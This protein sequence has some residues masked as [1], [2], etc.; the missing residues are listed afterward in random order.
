MMLRERAKHPSP[1]KKIPTLRFHLSNNQK[2]A[3]LTRGMEVKMVVTF[4]CMRVLTWR[5]ED[6]WGE[7]PCPG[8]MGII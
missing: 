5:K 7:V 2:W 1:P 3:T 6:F 4:T 8:L